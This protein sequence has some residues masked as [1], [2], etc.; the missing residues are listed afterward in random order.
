MN[1]AGANVKIGKILWAQKMAER[2]RQ[3][4]KHKSDHRP[5][6]LRARDIIPGAHRA[7]GENENSSRIDIPSFDLAQDIMAEQRRLTAVRRKGPGGPAPIQPVS[8]HTSADLPTVPDRQK[9]GYGFSEGINTGWNPII[10]EIVSRDIEQL[11][12]GSWR[13]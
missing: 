6:V 10:A 12:S 13:T 8:L 5:D 4:D 9:S 11:C 1:H 7:T 2:D 3:T